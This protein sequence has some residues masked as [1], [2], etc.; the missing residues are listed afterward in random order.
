M[1]LTVRHKSTLPRGWAYPVGVELLS[2]VLRSVPHQS[3]DPVWFSHSEP[4][5][6]SARRRR[7]S[8]DLPLRVLEARY[9]RFQIGGPE[10]DRPMWRLH[11]MSVPSALKSWVRQGLI[12]Q[13]LPRV[14]TW[15]LQPFSPIALESQ[16]HCTVLLQE[17]Q[18]KL[19]LQWQDNGFERE[20]VEELDVSASRE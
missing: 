15:L 6:L 2:E 3:S 18:R 20:S 7:Q 4:H 1:T 5:S 8:E 13:G 9:T 14:R 11:V 10:P 12:Q 19:L 16:P 17:A